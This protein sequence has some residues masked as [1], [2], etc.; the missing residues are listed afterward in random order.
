MAALAYEHEFNRHFGELER[1][2]DALGRST[3][4]EA[5]KSALRIREWVKRVRAVRRL[6]GHLLYE[7]N[8]DERGRFRVLPIL[9]QVCEQVE[10]ILRGARIRIENIPEELRF[11]TGR[12]MEWSAILQN[13][14]V[15]AYNAILD[16]ERQI[17]RI[18]ARREKTRTAVVI[19]DTGHGID[20]GTADELFKPFARQTRISPERRGL[21]LGGSGLGLTIVKMIADSLGCS[22]RFVS[23]SPG[24][25][26]AFELSWQ[27]D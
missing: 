14:L 6:F 23:P 9:K 22:I 2:A 7:E 1:I 21:G 11:P 24:Y 12:F 25:A 4:E 17:I 10:G 5:R 16:S 20:L 26:T 8:R 15:N 18:T 19:E 27:E 3:E 13:V